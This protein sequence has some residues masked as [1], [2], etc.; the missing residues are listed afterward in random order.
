M[1]VKSAG[2]LNLTGIGKPNQVGTVAAEANLGERRRLIFRRAWHK[3]MLFILLTTPIV[4]CLPVY[5]RLSTI[6][7]YRKTA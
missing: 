5:P 3:G 6:R 1:V 2:N 7:R 4:K